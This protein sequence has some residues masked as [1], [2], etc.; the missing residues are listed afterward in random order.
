MSTTSNDLLDDLNSMTASLE[1]NPFEEKKEEV[2]EPISESKKEEPKIEVKKEEPVVEVKTETTAEPKKEVIPD[3]MTKTLAELR[4][5]IAELKAA[6]VEAKP[7]PKPEE[8]MIEDQDFTKD[9]DLDEV[10]RSPEELNKLLNEVH[11]RAV[12]STK[13][14]LMSQLPDLVNKHIEVNRALR[15]IND[16]FYKENSDLVGFKTV[17]ALVWKE[18]S[19]KGPDRSILDVVKEVA[20][21]VRKRLGLTKSEPKPDPKP[22]PK[23][24]DA[25]KLPRK[26]Y[27]AR[28]EAEIKEEKD[29]LSSQIA[30]MNKVLT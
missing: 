18:L 3:E 19:E 22:E 8:P 5:E 10:S 6:K 9:L 2:K 16:N 29:S 17:V 27:S 21:E 13:K 4:A 11:K 15:E 28:S 7:E 1:L 25:P 14:A 12:T 24:N 26:S 30:D 20:P 23:K